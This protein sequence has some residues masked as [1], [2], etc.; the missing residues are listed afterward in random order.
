M[1]AARAA[2]LLVP[3]AFESIT[4][5][6]MYSC[7][8]KHFPETKDRWDASQ[9]LSFNDWLH[10]PGMPPHLPDL[11]A[12]DAL[13]RPAEELAQKWAEGRWDGE[14]LEQWCCGSDFHALCR[15]QCRGRELLA[16]V[17]DAAL[18]GHIQEQ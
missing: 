16:D 15:G 2:L 3:A 10:N 12:G 8:M 5:E 4:A 7:F 9:R 14:G 11:S 18:P 13:S 17:Q 1:A 6:E